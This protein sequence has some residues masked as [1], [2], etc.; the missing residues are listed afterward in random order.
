MQQTTERMS[1]LGLRKIA[2]DLRLDILEMTTASGTGME[3]GV[4]GWVARVKESMLGVI[5]LGNALLV[6]ARRPV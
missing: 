2:R 1:T 5:Y 4:A 6:V 3:K